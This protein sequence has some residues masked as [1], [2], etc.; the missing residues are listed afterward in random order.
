MRSILAVSGGRLMAATVLAVWMAGTAQAGGFGI[1]EQSTEFQGTSYA[2]VATG[3]HGLS[4]MFWNPA[5]V[6]N[7]PGMHSEWNAALVMPY[8]KADGQTVAAGILPPGYSGS[9]GNIGK[10]AV[11]PASYTSFQLNDMIWLGLAVNSPFGMK[12]KNDINSVG[13]IYGYESEIFTANINPMVGLKLGGMLSVGFGLQ[14]NYMEGDLSRANLGTVTSRVKGDDWGVGFTV[15][16]E[17]RPAEGTRIGVGYRSRI[18]HTLKGNLF[19]NGLGTS[20]ATVKHTLPDMLTVSASQQVTERLKLMGTV[21][22]VNWSLFKTF[23]VDSAPFD[24]APEAYNWKDGWLFAVGGEYAVNDMLSVRAGYAY[25]KSPVPDATRNVR[26]PDNDRH[27]LSLGLTYT[28][29]DWLKLHAAYSHL[30][31]KDGQVNIPATA[32]VLPFVPALPGLQATYK[33]H[34]NIVAISATVD[35]GKLFFGH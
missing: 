14:V 26:V 2:G 23:D 32:A 3:G 20:S 5:T 7:L 35:T 31:I 15:G 6:T 34:A 12:T 13:A 30:I 17:F 8:S 28:A 33:N 18:K 21:E 1:R 4:S 25:E 27:W 19:V 24:P 22:W 16:L 11:V 10:A 9:S 29:N